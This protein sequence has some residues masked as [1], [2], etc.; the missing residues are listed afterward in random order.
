VC[1]RFRLAPQT[2]RARKKYEYKEN[3]KDG[4]N[5]NRNPAGQGQAGFGHGIAGNSSTA[6]SMSIP[7]GGREF[8]H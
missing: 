8:S 3:Y 4:E 6:A 2:S 5:N 7:A 1:R